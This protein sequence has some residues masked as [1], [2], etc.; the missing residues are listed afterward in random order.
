[1]T[2]LPDATTVT[3]GDLIEGMVSLALSLVLAPDD[4][5]TYR[6]IVTGST[7]GTT[8]ATT[9]LQGSCDLKWVGPGSTSLELVVPNLAYDPANLPAADPKGGPAEITIPAVAAGAATAGFT[10]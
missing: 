8:P 5:S 7:S 2:V 6:K 3:P 1:V 4:M 10:F 9:P